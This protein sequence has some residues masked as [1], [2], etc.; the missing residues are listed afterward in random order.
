MNNGD[1]SV[2]GAVG[3]SIE[4]ADYGTA[5]GICRAS[6]HITMKGLYMIVER[7]LTRQEAAVFLTDQGY[8]V[9]STTLAKY[10]SVGGGPIFDSFGRKPLYRPDDLLEW[11]KERSTGPRRSTADQGTNHV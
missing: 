2:F 3:K 11:A 7:R 1:K 8:P 5:Y 10:A 4:S 9:A 6:Q